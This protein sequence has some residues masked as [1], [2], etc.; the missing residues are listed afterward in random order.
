MAACSS[1]AVVREALDSENLPGAPHRAD[2]AAEAS[3]WSA[4]ARPAPALRSDI[5]AQ[6]GRQ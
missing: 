4:H 1:L 2:P 5:D 3:G 6:L